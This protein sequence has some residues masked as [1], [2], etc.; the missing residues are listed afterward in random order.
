M[1]WDAPWTERLPWWETGLQLPTS[2][3][4]NMSEN[5]HDKMCDGHFFYFQQHQNSL[6]S[7]SCQVPPRLCQRGE[8]TWQ[9]PHHERMK[10]PLKM[11]F[12]IRGTDFKILSTFLTCN[13]FKRKFC[14]KQTDFKILYTFLACNPL[15]RKFCIRLTDFKTMYTFLVCRVLLRHTFCLSKIKWMVPAAVQVVRQFGSH[16]LLDVKAFEETS[17]YSQH[18]E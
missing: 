13:P 15:K 3:V 10:N 1:Q 5:D 2:L 6:V 4:W 18:S 7:N 17:L 12:C 11:K 8:P 9:H 16:H 14:I